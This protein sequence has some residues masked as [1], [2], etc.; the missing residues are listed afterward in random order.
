MNRIPRRAFVLPRAGA[1]AVFPEAVTHLDLIVPNRLEPINEQVF[2]S[3]NPCAAHNQVAAV[4]VGEV[5]ILS[6]RDAAVMVFQPR[7]Q[8]GALRLCG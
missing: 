3:L 2:G 8:P 6:V 7:V 5:E 4:E 1:V